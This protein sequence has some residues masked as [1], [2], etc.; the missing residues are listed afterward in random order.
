MSNKKTTKIIR[1]FRE[2]LKNDW[3][4]SETKKEYEEAIG[5]LEQT[6]RIT[7]ELLAFEKMENKQK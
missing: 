7:S 4:D 3:I 6:E 1:E 5:H 2:W